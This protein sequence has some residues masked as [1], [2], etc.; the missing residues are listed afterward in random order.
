MSRSLASEQ[1]RHP[2]VAE[3]WGLLSEP[4]ERVLAV[5]R[6]Q[7][8]SLRCVWAPG[9]PNPSRPQGRPVHCVPWTARPCLPLASVPGPPCCCGS[10]P[11]FAGRHPPG[12]C[13]SGSLCSCLSPSR[14][15]SPGWTSAGHTTRLNKVFV[16]GREGRQE[17]G[18]SRGGMGFRSPESGLKVCAE[19]RPPRPFGV[20]SG[21]TR[22]LA[23]G[24]L[25]PRA[26]I[27][28]CGCDYL[29]VVEGHPF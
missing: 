11:R 7:G 5:T 16:I 26:A 6:T 22:C 27:T 24:F 29:L 18:V 9:D 10:S 15:K 20:T 23:S 25:V 14:W 4:R 13:D 21:P 8:W 12:L 17:G 1:G 19:T 3:G 28:V 2:G